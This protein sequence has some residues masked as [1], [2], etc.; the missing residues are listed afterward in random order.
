MNPTNSIKVN[1]LETRMMPLS[2]QSSLRLASL[3]TIKIERCFLV[4]LYEGSIELDKLHGGL[5]VFEFL[6]TEL[7]VMGQIRIP[8]IYSAHSSKATAGLQHCIMQ[9]RT[10]KTLY[11]KTSVKIQ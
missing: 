10:S 1:W 2:F 9:R 3:L 5:S 4:D 11:S 6:C 7:T 8:Q